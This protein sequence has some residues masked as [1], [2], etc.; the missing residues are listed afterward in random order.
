[1]PSLFISEN[2]RDAI[3]NQNEIKFLIF[4]LVSINDKEWR[5]IHPVHLKLI[6]DGYILYKNG[7]IVKE[8]ILEIFDNYKIL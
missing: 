3:D 4:S 5:E 6:L 2:M 7:S 8:L 1:M